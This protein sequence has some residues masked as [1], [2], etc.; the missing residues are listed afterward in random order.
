[1]R[2]I[3]K[4][5]YFKDAT[6]GILYMEDKDNPVWYTIER[7]WLGNEVKKSCIPEGNYRVVPHNGTEF[8]DVWTIKD[9]PG[10]SAILF[11]VGNWVDNST[12]CILPGLTSC[13]MRNPK[14]QLLEKAVSN[15]SQ[16]IIQMKKEIGYPSDFELTIKS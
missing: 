7:P 3:L 4:R 1:M 16:A 13:Y 6:T 15:S 10:R 2:L 11:H 5:T 9:V 8:K 12:G 14:S